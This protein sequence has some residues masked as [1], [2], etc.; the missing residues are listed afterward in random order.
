MKNAT[1]KQPMDD[2]RGHNFAICGCIEAMSLLPA[3]HNHI[4]SYNLK[5][6]TCQSN[7]FIAMS[8]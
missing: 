3:L 4:L 1:P 7:I 2:F 6:Q 5:G 8:L